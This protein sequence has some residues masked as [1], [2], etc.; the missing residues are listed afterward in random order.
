MAH[1]LF[2]ALRRTALAPPARGA[3]RT[4]AAA[5][6]AESL[7]VALS[8][9]LDVMRARQEDLCKL[10]AEGV[11]L[12][13]REGRELQQL[14]RALEL[15]DELQAARSEAADLHELTQ[16]AEMREEALLELDDV[17][18]RIVELQDG[19]ITALLPKDEVDSANAL[20]EV[21][22]A[23]GGDEASS[24][25]MEVFDMYKK[26]AAVKGWRYELFNI[27]KTEYGGLKEAF[28]LITGD[29]SYAEL[30]FESGVHRVQ[31]VPANDSRIQT[32]TCTVVVLPQLDDHGDGK[33]ILDEGDLKIDVYRASGAG[34][35]HVNTT[36]SA[37]RI[38]HL[39]TGIIVAN[40]DERSQHMNKAKAMKLLAARIVGEKMAK[41]QRER[42]SKRSELAGTGDRSERIRTYNFKDD[43]VVDH[44]VNY[45]ANS[46]QG[47]LDGLML[48]EFTDK[49]LLWQRDA[50]LEAL[51]REGDDAAK[52]AAKE[53]AKAAKKK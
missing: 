50:Q 24:F 5:P 2:L 36:N 28:A 9:R 8:K 18:P 39:P 13:A 53:A 23:A 3:R 26:Y 22:A 27:S 25:A 7:G 17:E 20:I 42:S 41:E 34:G 1:R 10:S 6:Q 52:E 12:G 35:Q 40:Q 16:D 11:L 45:L 46:V 43:R 48:G 31:R 49:L 15:D 47:V 32:S 44:R 37:V 51:N 19:L 21:R 38:T 30:K 4:F 14:T 33:F 29:G